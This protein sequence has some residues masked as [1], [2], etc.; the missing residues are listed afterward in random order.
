[1]EYLQYQLH[2]SASTLAIVSFVFDLLSNY[3]ICVVFFWGGGRRDLVY[4]IVL[5]ENL[6][7]GY[8]RYYLMS[9]S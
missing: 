1:M 7:F 8:N 9:I 5:H 6:N 4:K 2:V 3:T